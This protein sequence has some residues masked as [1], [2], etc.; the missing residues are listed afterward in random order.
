MKKSHLI[1]KKNLLL[2]TLLVIAPIACQTPKNV[3]IEKGSS[4]GAMTTIAHKITGTTTPQEHKTAGI[5]YF[6]KGM[7][8][9]ASEEL[10]IASESIND[11][12]ELHHYLGKTY[13]EN[14]HTDEAITELNT[15]I[16][17]YKTTQS[18]EKADAYNDLGLAFKRKNAV[19]ESLYAVK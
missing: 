15:A 16:P 11:D 3:K 19:S 2:L 9:E 6:K 7:I 8:D 18:D 5:S 10:K 13:Y 4:Q 17:L 12:A 14:D 1:I